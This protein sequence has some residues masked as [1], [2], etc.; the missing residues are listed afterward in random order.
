MMKLKKKGILITVIMIVAVLLGAETGLAAGKSVLPP[1]PTEGTESKNP[2]YGRGSIGGVSSLA[3]QYLKSGDC[4]IK[5]VSGNTVTVGGSTS[6]YS[7]VDTIAVDLYL[8]RWDSSQGVWVDVLHVGE[9]KN[10]NLS[11]IS[12]SKD[13]SVPSGYYYRSRAHHWV[14][15]GGVTE[16]AYSYSSYIFVE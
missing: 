16:Q 12:G 2:R 3:T 6:A 10:N 5:L 1:S 13:V 7:S 8:Q 9:F 14:N 11:Q 4:Y 15:E